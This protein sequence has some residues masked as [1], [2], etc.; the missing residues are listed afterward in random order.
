LLESVAAG[1]IGDFIPSGIDRVP[2]SKNTENDIQLGLAGQIAVRIV[3]DARLCSRT[4]TGAPN[5]RSPPDALFFISA[6][7]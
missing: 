7:S 1:R 3:N 6:I 2:V 4:A 5:V